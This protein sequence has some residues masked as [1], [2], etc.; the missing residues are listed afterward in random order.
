MGF[1]NSIGLLGTGDNFGSGSGAGGA[2]GVGTGSDSFSEPTAG[3]LTGPGTGVKG[4]GADNEPGKDIDCST[5]GLILRSFSA[6]K[7][8]PSSRVKLAKILMLATVRH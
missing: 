3:G 6:S 7:R 8:L 2:S 5:G 4:K 1:G